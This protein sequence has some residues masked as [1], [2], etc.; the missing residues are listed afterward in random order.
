MVERGIRTL[1]QTLYEALAELEKDEVIQEAL[2]PIYTE[3]RSV[4][5]A[6]WEEYHSKVTAWEVDRFL[7]LL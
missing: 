6:E 1:P 3:F 2:G 5:Q 7:T 4:K